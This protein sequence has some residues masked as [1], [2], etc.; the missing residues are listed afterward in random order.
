MERT[1]HHGSILLISG[2]FIVW[3]GLFLGTL[4]ALIMLAFDRLPDQDQ[5]I[6]ES[7][8]KHRGE[9]HS[10]T[11]VVVVSIV[12]ACTVAYP[13][14]LGQRIAVGY[15]LL[16]STLVSPFRAWVFIIAV[17]TVGMTTHIATD[18]ITEGGGYKIK[19]L[20]PLSSRTFALGLCGSDNPVWNFALFSAGV[21]AIC[22]AIVHEIYYDILPVLL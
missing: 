20:W 3:L 2:F 22:L 1:G 21:T 8:I 12:A 16:S 10:I 13:L 7:V 15:D 18:T 17:S 6:P 14:H 4:A 11:F 9:T 19:P 5:Y